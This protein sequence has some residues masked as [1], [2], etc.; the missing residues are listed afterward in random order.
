LEVYKAAF[1]KEHPTLTVRGMFTNLAAVDKINS[2][3]W[4]SASNRWMTN[5]P[6]PN[7]VRYQNV[8]SPVIAPGTVFPD[9]SD[10]INQVGS[11]GQIPGT[12]ILKWNYKPIPGLE[13]EG[14]LDKRVI[15][16]IPGTDVPATL[17]YRSLYL[18]QCVSYRYFLESFYQGAVF[19]TWSCIRPDNHGHE[20]FII[21]M[22]EGADWQ[23]IEVEL[24]GL[25]TV[26]DPPGGPIENRIEL[27]NF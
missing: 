13:G 21:K 2:L 25:E 4:T 12:C 11:N 15:L 16:D 8:E 24:E 27:S 26:D 22:L 7:T 9:Y 23:A 6:L 10:T 18:N 5:N 20:G 1:V 3:R 19:A 14:P 17:K